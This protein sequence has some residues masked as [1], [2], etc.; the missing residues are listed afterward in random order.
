MTAFVAVH[1]G[2]LLIAPNDYLIAGRDDGIKNYFVVA[3]YVK[4]SDDYCQISSMNYPYGEFLLLEDAHPFP[5]LIF[6][7]VTEIFPAANNYVIGYINFL[8]LVS[9]ILSAWMMFLILNHFKVRTLLAITGAVS[10]TALSSQILLWGYGHWALGYVCCFPLGWFLLIRSL[11]SP[12]PDKWI[13]LTGLNA[14]LWMYVHPYLGL[15][16][17][18]FNIVSLITNHLTGFRNSGHLKRYLIA[19]LF[20]L[21][22]YVLSIKLFDTH[23]DRPEA[24]FF[25]KHVATWRSLLISNDTPVKYF[26]SLFDFA[27]S[28]SSWDKVGNYIGISTILVLIVYCGVQGVRL[29]KRQIKLS[30]LL[31]TE[32]L[33][34]WSAAVVTLNFAMAIPFRVFPDIDLGPFS[35]LMQFSS[36]GRFAWVFYFIATTFAIYVLSSH[37]SRTRLQRATGNILVLILL[38]EGYSLHAKIGAQVPD[39]P[40]IFSEEHLEEDFKMALSRFDPNNYQAIISLPFYYH[41]SN[42]YNFGSSAK[43]IF[44]SMMLSYH[45]SLPMMNAYL[46]RPSI[47]EGRNISQIFT[48]TRIT[49]NVEADL[50]DKRPF[51]IYHT[52]EDLHSLEQQLLDRAELSYSDS[53]G[54][55][56]L[57][58]YENLFPEPEPIELLFPDSLRAELTFNNGGFSTTPEALVHQSFEDSPSEIT[59]SGIGAFSCLNSGRYEIYRFEPV[60]D[61]VENYELSLWYFNNNIR[62]TYAN[63]ELQI[64]QT[65]SPPVSTYH[66]PFHTEVIYGNWSLVS[67]QFRLDK[68]Q[69]AMVFVNAGTPVRDSIYID[70]LLIRPTG[71]HVFREYTILGNPVF[72]K[73]NRIYD[74]PR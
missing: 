17:L 74:L 70:D 22:I 12:N 32:W 31:R 40:N 47:T 54:D 49:K 28:D 8:L 42:P 52:G 2:K 34:Y 56:Y 4:N 33:I 64:I 18:M 41:Y 38:I 50:T 55:F 59:F 7:L 29:I 23:I 5:A 57:L 27:E 44:N 14:M 26:Y 11:H 3:S 68:N 72:L 65:N 9:L 46:S 10:I 62:Q 19:F 1:F 20:P 51:L 71:V 58:S 43:S 24:F 37:F 36:Y 63:I 39:S 45:T 67:I 73:D 66:N 6:K 15:M 53:F 48:N 21:L 69:S 30:H 13:F 25:D 60:I 35:V 16:L 61:S